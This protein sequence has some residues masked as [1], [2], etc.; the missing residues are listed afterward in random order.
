MLITRQFM[1]KSKSMILILRR[2]KIGFDLKIIDLE[3]MSIIR[4][5][6][7]TLEDMSLLNMTPPL[8]RN[9]TEHFIKNASNFN[10][11]IGE[12]LDIY[13]KR[14]SIEAAYVKPRF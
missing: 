1:N 2:V 8:K 7:K 9:V 4:Q 13:Q 5:K 3:D 12:R 14:R 11:W 6:T 10:D